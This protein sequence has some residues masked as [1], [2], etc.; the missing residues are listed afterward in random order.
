MNM[1]F[2]MLHKARVVVLSM[3][4]VWYPASGDH[5]NPETP[6][7]TYDRRTIIADTAMESAL[8]GNPKGFGTEE[9]EQISK[10]H[11]IDAL[12]LIL[13]I[14]RSESGLDYYTHAGESSHIGTQ[15]SGRA[16]CLGQVQ[17]WA[18]NTLLTEEEHESLAGIGYDA[19]L[20]CANAIHEYLWYH[21]VRCRVRAK[22]R[23]F[24]KWVNHHR[25]TDYEAQ[26]L[27]AYY[28]KGTCTPRFASKKE[29]QNLYKRS[30][31][32][33]EIRMALAAKDLPEMPERPVDTN[34][35]ASNL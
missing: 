15:D 2:A 3:S 9:R 10:F 30:E 16:R 25:M 17:T 20:R 6:A 35:V 1:L 7:E 18:G 13:T 27:M 12:A 21:A 33:R 5:S 23:R 4:Q 19:T 34:R 32:F 31:L 24:S 26:R 22:G 28:A 14:E 11:P 8:R 29:R